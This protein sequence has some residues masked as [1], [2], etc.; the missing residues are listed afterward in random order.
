MGVMSLVFALFTAGY[1]L[2]VW[3]ACLVF[4][5]PQRAFEEGTLRGVNDGAAWRA[6]DRTPGLATVMARVPV[7]ELIRQ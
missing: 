7:V 6:T 4:R 1:I 2:G 3:T 5:Q